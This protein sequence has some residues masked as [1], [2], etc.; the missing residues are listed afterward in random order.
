[1]FVETQWFTRTIE[2][3]NAYVEKYDPYRGRGFIQITHEDNYAK[4]SNNK[5]KSI[6]NIMDKNKSK[7]AIDLI[8]AGDTSGWFWRYGSI[9]N[10]QYLDINEVASQKDVSK[11]TRRINP[12]LKHLKEREKAFNAIMKIIDYEKKCINKI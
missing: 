11:V 12:A 8:L 6:S 1:M 3:D 9:I 4:Y 10:G 2:G 5:E 7:V